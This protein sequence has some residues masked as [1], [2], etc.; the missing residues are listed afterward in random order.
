MGTGATGYIRRL[1]VLKSLLWIME[2]G[3]IQGDQDFRS[4][5][6]SI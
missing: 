5:L 6:R 3:R 1:W 4:Q 2:W